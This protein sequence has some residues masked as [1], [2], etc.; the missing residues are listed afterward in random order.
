[1]A[2]RSRRHFFIVR[3]YGT[4]LLGVDF[5]IHENDVNMDHPN[6]LMVAGYLLSPCR[7]H[8]EIFLDN[9]LTSWWVFPGKPSSTDRGFVNPIRLQPSDIDRFTVVNVS[10]NSGS[11]GDKPFSTGHHRVGLYK[12][13]EGGASSRQLSIRKPSISRYPHG[14]IMSV[15]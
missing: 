6:L 14:K 3:N 7:S 10:K 13:P 9:S 15:P 11:F 4:H 12:A 8:I 5:E 2:R 1:M